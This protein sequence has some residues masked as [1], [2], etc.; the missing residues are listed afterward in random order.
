M[1]S[2]DNSKLGLDVS[3]QRNAVYISELGF[4]VSEQCFD[5]DE[6]CSVLTIFTNI[7]A[8]QSSLTSKLG[9]SISKYN[10]FHQC[11]RMTRY[12]NVKTD[13]ARIKLSPSWL[14]SKLLSLKSKDK[15]NWLETPYKG[16]S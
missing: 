5:L 15:K 1:S 9:K 6:H 2:F 13:D 3:E 10:H 14:A 11:Q 8:W 16:V 12:T 4:D 7:N